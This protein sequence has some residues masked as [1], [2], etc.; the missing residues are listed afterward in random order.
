MRVFKIGFSSRSVFYQ[1]SLNKTNLSSAILNAYIK[2]NNLGLAQTAISI[3]D[4]ID[5]MY[6]KLLNNNKLLEEVLNGQAE[7]RSLDEG[8]I[9]Q[10]TTKTILA[11]TRLTFSLAFAQISPEL[12]KK[13][14]NWINCRS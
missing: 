6:Y 12:L 1:S 3:V 4:D 11:K 9:F 14:D 7:F 2:E 13:A 5:K 8:I 10:T